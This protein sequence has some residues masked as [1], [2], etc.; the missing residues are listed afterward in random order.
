MLR[1]MSPFMAQSRHGL[2]RCKCLLLT[3]SGLK[4]FIGL[5]FV[6]HAYLGKLPLRYLPFPGGINFPHHCFNLKFR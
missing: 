1:R 4:S 3:Q 6:S 2:V 5:G